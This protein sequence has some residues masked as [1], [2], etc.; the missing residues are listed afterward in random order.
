MK[1]FVVV[2]L[3]LA[4]FLVGC[5]KP[6]CDGVGNTLE[7]FEFLELGMDYTEV[8]ACVGTPEEDPCSGLICPIY[9][10]DDGT[11]I[12]LEI[13]WRKVFGITIVYP[14]GTSK[15][16]THE[17]KYTLRELL[18][19]EFNVRY[20]ELG[21]I[22]HLYLFLSVWEY[23]FNLEVA[24]IEI[25]ESLFDRL[26]FLNV[27]T[28]EYSISLEPGYSFEMRVKDIDFEDQDFVY[29]GYVHLDPVG[30]E[31]DSKFLIMIDKSEKTVSLVEWRDSLY[32]WGISKSYE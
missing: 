26:G 3:L 17:D 14:D 11:K 29:V 30:E 19:G 9:V 31:N 25:P 13:T 27:P 10:L 16:I 5:A 1:R 23:K 2:L 22:G 15:K 12:F 32:F 20:G 8:T 21:E 7:D 28:G 4:V 6:E 18:S 24:E